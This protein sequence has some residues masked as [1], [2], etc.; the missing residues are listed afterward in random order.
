MNELRLQ[1][2]LSACQND[3]FFKFFMSRPC[4]VC[5]SCCCLQRG[6]THV[7]FPGEMT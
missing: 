2:G 5:R 7:Q 6:L 3:Y 4:V 1:Q